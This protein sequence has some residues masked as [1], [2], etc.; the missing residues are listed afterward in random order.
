MTSTIDLTE[1]EQMLVDKYNLP[2]NEILAKKAQRAEYDKQWMNAVHLWIDAKQWRRAHDTYC[3]YVFHETLLKGK[4]PSDPSFLSHSYVRL[5]L[6]S[7]N[8]QSAKEKL[9]SLDHQRAMIAHWNRRGGFARQYIELL[10]TAEKVQH[11]QV[12]DHRILSRLHEENETIETRVDCRAFRSRL[13]IEL[14]QVSWLKF[15]DC[16]INWLMLLLRN[17]SKSS[18]LISISAVHLSRRSF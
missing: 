1:D 15:I 9:D 18:A 17:I 16:A 6:P 3:S 4:S 11:G 7:G 13:P 2:L 8:Y 12:R 5:S 10:I 14:K